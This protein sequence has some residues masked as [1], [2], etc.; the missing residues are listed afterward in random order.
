VEFP[1]LFGSRRRA[2]S[3]TGSVQQEQGT[4]R[5]LSIVDTRRL[6]KKNLPQ[7]D[8]VDHSRQAGYIVQAKW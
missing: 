2:M 7:L 8:L 6:L 4:P 5:S 3:V 1:F